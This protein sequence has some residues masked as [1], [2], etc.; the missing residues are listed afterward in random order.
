MIRIHFRML[1]TL[2]SEPVGTS[3]KAWQCGSFDSSKRFRS[4]DSDDLTA[5]IR[6]FQISLKAFRLPP[7]VL[8]LHPLK[9]IPNGFEPSRRFD[10]RRSEFRLQFELRS[11]NFKLWKSHVTAYSVCVPPESFAF[12]VRIVPLLALDHSPITFGS[13]SDFVCKFYSSLSSVVLIWI[14]RS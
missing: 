14:F 8:S 10:N 9:R 11:L 2:L 7:S 1:T 13:K 6:S 12:S 5:S 4:S 3:N